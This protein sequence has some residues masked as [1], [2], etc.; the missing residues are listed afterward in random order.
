M[1]VMCTPEEPTSCNRRPFISE[2][3]CDR[4]N[5]DIHQFDELPYCEGISPTNPD[6]PPEIVA[7]PISLPVPPPCSC[8]KIEF[9]FP[10]FRYTPERTFITNASF[11]SVGDCCEGN[12]KSD[13]N[14]EMPCPIVGSGDNRIKIGIG[15]GDGEGKKE[16]KYVERDGDGCSITT[17]DVDL[18]LQIPCPISGLLENKISAKLGWAKAFKGD[19]ALFA[20]VSGDKCGV[21]L[22]SNEL[23]LEIPCPINGRENAKITAEIAYGEGN[24]KD[25]DIIMKMNPET[26][27][28]EGKDAE[29][30]LNLPCPVKQGEPPTINVDIGYGNSF[31]GDRK[32]LIRLN[33]EKCSIEPESPE[34]ELSIPCPL[35]KDKLNIKT[36]FSTVEG[37]GDFK[38]VDDTE[39]ESCGRTIELHVGFPD[40]G[41]GGCN[42]YSG[43]RQVVR[44]VRWSTTSFTFYAMMDTY[45]YECGALVR[46]EEGTEPETIFET[47]AHTSTC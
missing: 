36:S 19:S 7:T 6:I 38:V 42:G 37:A 4:G 27:R 3:G 47:I 9:G 33:S 10:I 17:N 21:E 8:F 23:K 26:C 13:F 18:D 41:G 12:Y 5:V 39:D 14:I 24:S 46:V 22:F 29:I 30:Y 40:I 25:S 20:R 35:K 2:D 15:Y 32:S 1:N 31:K 44:Y 45:V 16:A 43:T 34:I 28:I 11:K